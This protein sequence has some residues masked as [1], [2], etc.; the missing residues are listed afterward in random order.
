[1]KRVLLSIAL[2]LS[3]P[4]LADEPG[5]MTVSVVEGLCTVKAVGSGGV[6]PLLEGDPLREGDMVITSPGA[7]L[8]IA[9]ANGTVIRLG[10]SSRLLLG[11]A[12]P[13]GGRFSARLFVGSLWTKVHKLLASETF[14]VE[15]EN[16]VAGVRGTEFRVEAAEGGKDD[17]LRVYEGAVEVKGAAGWA[18][19]VTPGNEL[20]FHRDRPP[21]GPKAF[22]P[23]SE[24]S[25]RLMA[26]V[27][28]KPPRE[29]AGGPHRERRESDRR[30][31]K[32]ERK[33]R[34]LERTRQHRGLHGR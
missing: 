17:L 27:R 23:A 18:H 19:S 32:H 2:L 9:V 16:A 31:R 26:W 20:A 24:K 7:R 10:E 14:H 33:E 3:G 13:S 1:M 6:S 34:R 21:A 28:E 4:A 5:A 8:E 15:T 30:D 22:D 11:T 29:H 12:P 25:S